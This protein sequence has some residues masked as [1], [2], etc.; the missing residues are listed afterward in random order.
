MDT[1][2]TR[3]QRSSLTVRRLPIRMNEHTRM[4]QMSELTTMPRVPDASVATEHTQETIDIQSRDRASARSPL[5]LATTLPPSP[6]N[7]NNNRNA[8][9]QSPSTR[10]NVNNNSSSVSPNQMTPVRRYPLRDRK[11]VVKMDL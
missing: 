8:Q 5:L 2:L 3:L 9:R 10:T 7:H 1:N 6:Q 4:E 11:P